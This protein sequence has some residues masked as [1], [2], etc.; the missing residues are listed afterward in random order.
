MNVILFVR[1]SPWRHQ[2]VISIFEE[3]S[4]TEEFYDEDREINDDYADQPEEIIGKLEPLKTVYSITELLTSLKDNDYIVVG[5]EI[6][7]LDD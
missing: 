3:T 6:H 5:E 4:F 7:S 1:A 2:V